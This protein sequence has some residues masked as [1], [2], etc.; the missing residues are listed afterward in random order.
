MNSSDEQLGTTLPLTWIDFAIV[1][2]SLVARI[3]GAV[4]ESLAMLENSMLRAS[5]YH[6]WRKRQKASFKADI[7]T[8]IEA[9]SRGEK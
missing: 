4:Y 6:S 8:D 5:A 7:G 1:P 2:V 9:L 3:G